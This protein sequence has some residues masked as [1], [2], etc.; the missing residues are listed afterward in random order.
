M[1]I[2]QIMGLSSKCSESNDA[3]TGSFACPFQFQLPDGPILVKRGYK[4]PSATDIT[5]AFLLGLIQ[6]NQAIPIL[7][8]FNFEPNTEDDVKETSNTGIT[9]LARRGLTTLMFTYKKGIDHEKALEKL[10]SFGVFDVWL[11]DK[12]GNLLGIDKS[13]DFGGFSAGLVLPKSR[14]WNDGSV[15]EGKAL[16]IQLTKP[17]QFKDMTWIEAGSLPMFLPTE[18]QGK[19]QTILRFEDVNGAVPPA[20]TDTTV[21]VRVLAIDGITP[22][23]GLVTNQFRSI[24]NIISAVVDDGNGYYTIT[25]AALVASATLDI[26]IFDTVAGFNSVIVNGFLFNGKTTVVVAP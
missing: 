25:L 20:A 6:S 11:V 18:F 17:G 12:S 4:I 3:N 19:N 5:T 13:G 10:L 26:E 15:A 21:K 14:T 8:A 7:D 16:E 24:S 2:E 9:T 22:V 1:T 23:P